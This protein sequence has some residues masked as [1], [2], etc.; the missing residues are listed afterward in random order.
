M[1][2][3]NNLHFRA[4]NFQNFQSPLEVLASCTQLSGLQ[5]TAGQRTMSSL[6]ADLTG[7]T[8]VLPV[9]LTGYFFIQTL[10]FPYSCRL[11]LY[12][13]TMISFFFGIFCYFALNPSKKKNA[14][15]S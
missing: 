3:H 4:S 15:I 7:Q 12:N 9:I 5:I 1:S 2:I 14:A 13:A 10:Y 11:M 8:P 6:I